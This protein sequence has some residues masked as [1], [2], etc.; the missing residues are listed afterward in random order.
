M[1]NKIALMLMSALAVGCVQ[2]AETDPVVDDRV[3]EITENLLAA[4]YTEEDIEVVDNEDPLTL[5]GVEILAAGPQ[6]IVGGDV[7]VT[8]EAARELVASDD[9]EAFRQWRTPTLVTNNNTICLVRP[10]TLIPQIG[11][12]IVGPLSPDMATGVN[13]ARHNYN[14]L[15]LGLD[16]EIRDGEVDINGNIFIDAAAAAGCDFFISFVDSFGGGAAGGSSGFPSGGV[17]YG[18]VSLWG[19]ASNQVFEHLATH[20]IGHAIGLRHSD[21][22]TRL[23]CGQWVSEPQDGAVQIP[24]TAFHTTNSIMAACYP[25]NTNGEFRGEDAEALESIY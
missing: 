17:P 1:P 11:P 4:G 12:A 8:L 25:P 16:F 21:W 19:N 3:A 14:R 5:N 15:D 9:D 23:S 20:E 2:D 24:N 18:L 13:F 22:L 10:L 6:V 7:H